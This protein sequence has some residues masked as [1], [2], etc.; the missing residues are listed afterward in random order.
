MSK[1]SSHSG[2][3]GGFPADDGG[4]QEEEQGDEGLPEGDEDMMGEE[5]LGQLSA[6]YHPWVQVGLWL[7][8]SYFMAALQLLYG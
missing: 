7:I 5:E 8:Y 2:C 3:A 6:Q 4:E 1:R